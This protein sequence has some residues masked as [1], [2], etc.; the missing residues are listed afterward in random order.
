MV[1]RSALAQIRTKRPDGSD[2]RWLGSYGI[3]NQLKYSSTRPGGDAQLTCTLNSDPAY[4][5]P[6]IDPGRYCEAF[7]GAS[8]I[9]YGQMTEPV[10]TATGWNVT[11]NG[12]GTLGAN[13]LDIWSTW[14]QNDAINE[15]ISR[16]LPWIN[17]GIS[18]GYLGQS[19]DSGSQSITDFLNGM[20]ISPPQ[21]W[22]LD[23]SATLQVTSVPSTVTRLLVATVGPG[24]TINADVNTIYVKYTATDNTKSGVTTYGLTSVQNASL[25]AAHGENEDY[26]DLTGQGVLSGSAARSIASDVLSKYQRAPF[27]TAFTVAPGQY[28]NAGGTPVDLAAEQ[29]GEVVRLLIVDS[30]FGGEVVMGPIQ[31]MVGQYEYD[32]TTELGSVTPY[33]SYK[34]DLSSILSQVLAQRAK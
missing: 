14:N 30:P 25:V 33:L 15:A 9:W 23:R 7:L 26:I 18:S 10:Q 4:R 8:R 34:T 6:A 24:R 11:A 12:I 17:P 31:F 16:G 29:A 27:S 3:V 32:S 13:F 22:Y 2:P 5:V 1:W 28:L 21:I 19:V 20:M